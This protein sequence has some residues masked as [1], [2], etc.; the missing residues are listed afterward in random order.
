MKEKLISEYVN[1]MTIEDVRNFAIQNGGSLFEKRYSH[2]NREPLF[3]TTLSM[4]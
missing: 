3:Y 1:R 4:Q 2:C